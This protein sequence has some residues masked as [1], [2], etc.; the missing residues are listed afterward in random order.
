M[1]PSS[2]TLWIALMCIALTGQTAT[3]VRSIASGLYRKY[4]GFLLWDIASGIKSS[5]LLYTAYWFGFAAPQYVAAWQP[6]ELTA[7][8]CLLFV[9]WEAYQITVENYPSPGNYGSRTLILAAAIALTISLF[10]FAYAGAGYFWSNPTW[11]AAI[12]TRTATFTVGIGLGIAVCRLRF[13][14]ISEHK[15]LRNLRR[16]IWLYCAG[17]AIGMSMLVITHNTGWIAFYLATA[18][19]CWALWPF[20]MTRAGEEVAHRAYTA[21]EKANIQRQWTEVKLWLGLAVASLPAR[22]G[23]A[24]Q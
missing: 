10:P 9:G 3:F 16:L 8:A 24:R 15:N 7:T 20:A 17:Q 11:I 1:T 22:R 4:P 5:I 18:A 2:P 23:V 14:R 19:V 12:V 13:V 6:L 21:E